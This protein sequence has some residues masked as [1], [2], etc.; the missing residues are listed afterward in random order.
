LCEQLGNEPLE[1]EIPVERE[2]LYWETQEVFE[3]YDLLSARW[4]GMS[5]SY[6]GKDLNLLPM[7]FD[8]YDVPIYI[9]KY[10]LFIIPII[11]HHVGNDI[12]RKI[13]S[14]TPKT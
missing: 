10:A 12:A 1:E 13:K 5:G 7:L 14:K 9:K 3:L 11:D 4:E 6:L 8:L 2:D